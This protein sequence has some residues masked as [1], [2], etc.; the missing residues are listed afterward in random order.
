[1]AESRLRL[2]ERQQAEQ[3]ARAR[4]L[5]QR[6]E[7]RVDRLRDLEEGRPPPDRPD[8]READ[9]ERKMDRIL[10]ELGGLRRELRRRPGGKPDR[11]EQGP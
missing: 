6:A 4:Q 2:L 3:R 8:R 1:M 5:L 9:L 10:E 7:E 11:P